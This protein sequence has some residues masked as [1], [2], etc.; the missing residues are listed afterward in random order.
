M[1]SIVQRC[2]GSSCLV[3]FA[4]SGWFLTVNS[5]GFSLISSFKKKSGC[6][7]QVTWNCWKWHYNWKYKVH[8]LKVTCPKLTKTWSSV[9]WQVRP[10]PL[11]G[12]L[13]TLAVCAKMLAAILSPNAAMTPET[14]KQRCH[15]SHGFFFICFF[16]LSLLSCP[17]F[18]SFCV[19][20]STCSELCNC[21]VVCLHF[22]I[23]LICDVLF[24]Q[25]TEVP[26]FAFFRKIKQWTCPAISRD[27][28][29]KVV[30]FQICTSLQLTASPEGGPMKVMPFSFNL[31]GSLGFSLAWP[32]PGQTASTSDGMVLQK[33]KKKRR[34]GWWPRVTLPAAPWQFCKSG[35]HWHSCSRSCRLT[36]LTSSAV[37][38]VF[39]GILVCAKIWNFPLNLLTCFTKSYWMYPKWLV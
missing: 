32:Q 28:L 22:W 23:I 5:D 25:K 37:Y 21:V 31:A 38:A 29:V 24:V 11:Q 4:Y 14:R 17:C 18:V 36:D 15:R 6:K 35:P 12:M 13:G 8:K 7:L 34:K 16:C 1:K 9:S 19:L 27:C 26:G 2:A 39:F 30:T 33:K 3:W 10:S 20:V